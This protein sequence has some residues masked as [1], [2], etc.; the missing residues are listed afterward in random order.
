L[1]LVDRMGS[2]LVT[3]ANGHIGNETCRL[4]RAANQVILPIDTEADAARG[5]LA[6]DITVKDELSRLFQL[7]RIQTVIHLA[8]LLPSAF[9]SDPLRGAEVNLNGSFELMQ[10]ALNSDVRRFVFA[11]S[12]SVYGSSPS[13]RPLTEEDPATPDEP[14]GVSKRA[15]EIIGE[16][17][18]TGR[19]ME[20]VSLRIARVVGPGIKK[21][22][23]PWRSQI[24][25]PP[26]DASI[27]IPFAPDTVLSLVHVEDVARMLFVL[28]DTTELHNS[29]YNTAAELWQARDL[30]QLIVENVDTRVELGRESSA[31][32]ICD[33]GRF[34]GEFA[35]ELQG[36]RERLS[37]RKLNKV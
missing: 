16:T 22:A 6:C 9:R 37:R 12:M 36:L 17:L 21:T 8:G 28:A 7:H 26:G 5:V 14:Y 31:G 27:Q 3:G 32:P 34:V 35:F 23:S 25:D 11:S 30:K 29:V 10:Q 19:P 2:I 4:L 15:V 24:F 13:P 20:F 1:T 18:A 33:G